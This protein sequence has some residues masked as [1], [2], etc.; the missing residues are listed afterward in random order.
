VG[1]LL[2]LVLA[3]AGCTA[4]DAKD[5][6]NPC[7]VGDGDVCAS[8][9]LVSELGRS[10]AMHVGRQSGSC[11]GIK[12]L[13]ADELAL[14]W[15][16][17]AA[18]PFTPVPVRRRGDD[19]MVAPDAAGAYFIEA[20][21]RD[22][23]GAPDRLIVLVVDPKTEPVR[24]ALHPARGVTAAA[25]AV[26]VRWVPRAGADRFP[27]RRWPLWL[28]NDRAGLAAQ[29]LRLPPG[30]YDVEWTHVARGKSQTGV[31]AIE[32]SGGGSV[33]VPLTPSK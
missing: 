18:G 17:D 21:A 12:P 15:S 32:V 3:G 28:D 33:D 4:A 25:T 5:C 19:A 16:R 6:S 31:A 7:Q 30:H 26:K 1:A 8:V 11:G 20:A 10:L 13:A 14:T 22:G 2:S 27:R 24:L 23:H 29:P 9:R